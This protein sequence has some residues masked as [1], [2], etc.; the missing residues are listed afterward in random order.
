MKP[1][2]TIAPTFAAPR[3]SV[4]RSLAAATVLVATGVTPAAIQAHAA[5][6]CQYAASIGRGWSQL[7]IPP[8]TVGPTSTN[9]Y[10]YYPFYLGGDAIYGLVPGSGQVLL[11]TNGSQIMRSTNRGCTW[12]PVYTYQGGDLGQDPPQVDQAL[13]PT[14]TDSAGATG[15]TVISAFAFPRYQA[16]QQRLY[17]AV[18][19]SGNVG[20]SL[21][22]Q[23]VAGVPVTILTSTDD[24]QAWSA[25]TPAPSANAPAIPGC[26]APDQLAESLRLS[27][28][29]SDPR[30]LYL[31]CGGN[32]YGNAVMTRAADGA[33]SD[34]RLYESTD[35]GA[36]WV[37][38]TT[39]TTEAE[40]VPL[41]GLAVDPHHPERLWLATN[42]STTATASNVAHP[43]AWYS[44]DSGRT[45][46]AKA[47]G[48]KAN[49]NGDPKF[50]ESIGY[51]CGEFGVD[52]APSSASTV[53][54][55]TNGVSV[56]TDAGNHWS[57]Y[58]T[59]GGPAG[60]IIVHSV[61]APSGDLYGVRDLGLPPNYQ[62]PVF[63]ANGAMSYEQLVR[64]HGKK[65]SVVPTPS[66]VIADFFGL[67]STGT[68]HSTT[69]LG[70]A[71]V[72]PNPSNCQMYN[73]VGL[74]WT[75]QS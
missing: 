54:N 67:E 23:F 15:T 62:G 24:G 69:L 42:D 43:T 75:G 44:A 74:L 6:A 57:T 27:V 21:A 66:R 9:K 59:G 8:F 5:S 36:S 65:T 34:L 37:Q 45:W 58:A 12:S 48:G 56:S 19:P 20:P 39:P 14:G 38:R 1:S 11:A 70:F 50:A 46:S 25:V 4:R 29:T 52:V 49:L 35:G 63:C 26:E 2:R 3:S 47:T 18:A 7:A 30:V 32:A 61:F 72:R 53:A 71:Q 68:Q 22:A 17:A 10:R 31:A 64:V 60:T 41:Q 33:S 13:Q 40:G 28:A 16:K 55:A 73:N 51:C